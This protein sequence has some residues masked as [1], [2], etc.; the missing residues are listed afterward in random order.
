MPGELNSSTNAGIASVEREE[1]WMVFKV[2]P[3]KTRGRLYFTMERSTFTKTRDAP[4]AKEASR[5]AKVKY[6]S[7][8]NASRATIAT[9]KIPTQ[10]KKMRGYKRR[11][12]YPCQSMPRLIR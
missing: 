12:E 7:R 8:R 1:R 5:N 6:F 10:I 3:S 4:N 2:F 11:R 9:N